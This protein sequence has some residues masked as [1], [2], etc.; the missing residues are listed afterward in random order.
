MYKTVFAASRSAALAAVLTMLIF[1]LWH[2]ISWRYIAWGAYHGAGIA[3]WQWFQ[4][5]KGSVTAPRKGV[6]AY[7]WHALSILLTFHFVTFS[8]VLVL[9]PNLEAAFAVY[10]KLLMV[11]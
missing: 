6:W 10:A 2:E 11:N 3:V 5:W 4:G 1:G 7:L 8:F 9:E